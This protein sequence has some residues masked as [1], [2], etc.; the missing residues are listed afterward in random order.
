VKNAAHAR[1][2]RSEATLAAHARSPRSQPTEPAHGASP[3]SQPTE[4][5]HGASP[6]SQP[7]EPVHTRIVSCTIHWPG[8]LGLRDHS[9]SGMSRASCCACS[10]MLAHARACSRLRAR[11]VARRQPRSSRLRFVS[12]IGFCRG[13]SKVFNKSCLQFFR[14][15]LH[16]SSTKSNGGVVFVIF[17]GFTT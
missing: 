9:A 7:T 10:R 12:S 11:G 3:R 8:P 16:E 6:R 4:P 5:A 14:V 15:L 2:P 1:S 13:F 17:Q